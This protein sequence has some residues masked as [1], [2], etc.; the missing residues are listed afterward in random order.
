MPYPTSYIVHCIKL[1]WLKH[2]TQ[3]ALYYSVLA[4]TCMEDN[5][6][7]LKEYIFDVKFIYKPTC[8]KQQ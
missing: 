2:E 6:S 5:P 8:Q 4:V 7:M 3:S 1:G